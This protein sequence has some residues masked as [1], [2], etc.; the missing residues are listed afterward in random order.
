MSDA[1]NCDFVSWKPPHFSR[2][3]MTKRLDER[4]IRRIAPTALAGTGI[5]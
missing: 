3:A 5:E 1:P 4:S 2:V